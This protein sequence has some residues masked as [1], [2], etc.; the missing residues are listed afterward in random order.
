VLPE[1]LQHGAINKQLGLASDY[2]RA[3]ADW[4]DRAVGQTRH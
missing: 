4:I 2:T 1:A 3:V